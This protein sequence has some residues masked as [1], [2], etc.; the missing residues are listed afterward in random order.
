V[1]YRHLINKYNFPLTNIKLNVFFE[2]DYHIKIKINM[3]LHDRQIVD[4]NFKHLP[5]E[6]HRMI[7][8][9]TVPEVML[10]TWLSYYDLTYII[11]SICENNKGFAATML[12]E[13]Y[14][15]YNWTDAQ[16]LLWRHTI[17]V[18]EKRNGYW[19]D[20]SNTNYFK[21]SDQLEKMIKKAYIKTPDSQ[22]LYKVISL[23]IFTYKNCIEH[24]EQ[25]K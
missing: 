12:H 17:P 16:L 10:S 20:E 2:K 4:A 19:Y 21:F 1:H 8:S 13:I 25:E 14:S 23:I 22:N 7:Y 11:M 5:I 18:R 15:I 9:F 6:L 3:V 24:I